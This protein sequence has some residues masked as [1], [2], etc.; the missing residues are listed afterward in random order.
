MVDRRRHGHRRF[1]LHRGDGCD[2]HHPRWLD[3]CFFTVDVYGDTE[4]EANEW[5]SVVITNPVGATFDAGYSDLTGWT[6]DDEGPP[7]L[8]VYGPYDFEGDSGTTAFRFDV[9]LS[10]PVDTPVTF[11]WSTVDG[12]A[13]AGSDYVAVTGATATIPAGSTSASFTVDVYGDTE[14][15]AN[16]WFSVVITNPVGATF[17]ADYSDL[18]GW[19]R[20]D[21]G[22]ATFEVY[23]Y[24]VYEGDSGTTAV[25]F[26]VSLSHPVD[27]PVTFEW[28]TVD[29]T[30]TA[31][32]DYV[33]VTGATATIPAG[34]TSAS[35]TVDVYG[36]TEVEADERFSVV[37]TNPV[38]AT[39]DEDHSNRSGWIR[40]D[41]TPPTLNVYSSSVYEGD[42][43]TTAMTFRGYLSR[44]VDYDVTFEW[45]T[46]G[47]TATAGSDYVAVTGATA[48]IPAG[49]T[50]AE[51][52]TIDVYGDTEVEANEWFSVVITNP[53]G[54]TYASG[55]NP[56]GSIRNDDGPPTLSVYGSSVDEGDSGT[57]P[58]TFGVWLSHPV[59]TPV[60]FEWS[61]VDGTATAGSDY[62]A[63]TGATATIP[64]G[65]TSASFT[66][67]VN[68]DT[69]V[70]ADEW[71]SVVIT[72]PVGATYGASGSSWILDDDT[73]PTLRVY[74]PYDFE[75]DSG[76]TAAT[77]DVSLSHPV[78]TPVT[79]EW[80]TVDRTATAGSDYI[81][82]T[83]ATA[84][85]PAGSTSASFTVDVYGD[86]EVEADEWFSVVITNPVGATYDAYNSDPSGSIRN[87]DGPPTLNVYSD[88]VYEGDSGTTA[89]TFGV[90]L[91]RSVDYDV[92]FEWSTVDGTATAGSD[93]V[94]V[95]GATAT[96]PAGST[97]ASFTV[98]VYGDTEVEANEWFSVVITNPVGATY[99]SGGNP[100]GSIL[101]DDTPPAL[102]VYSD[103]S[104]YEGDSGTTAMTFGVWLSRSVD[105][106]VT[107]EWSTVD[108]TATAGSDYVAVTGATA[109]IPA[110]RTDAELF[111]IDV[112]GDT[113]VEANEWFSVVITNPVG[114]TYAAGGNPSGSILDDDT[115][116]TLSVYGS[117]VDEGDSGTTPMT[118]RGYLSRSVDY[119]V[120]F[121]WSTVDGTATAGSDYVAVTG[122]TATIPAGSW[123]EFTVDVYGDTEAEDDEW[124]QV[125]I[126]NP[127]GATYAS[128]GNP[129]GSIL[130]DEPELALAD[131]AITEGDDGTSTLRFTPT[132]SETFYEDV[133]FTW[134]TQNGSATAGSDY[135]AVLSTP[136]TIPA[137]SL[138]TT[139]EVTV[140]GDTLY[141]A[142]ESFWVV[143]SSL[144]N[145]T[146]A[147]DGT[148]TGTITNDDDPPAISVDDVTITE[149]DSGTTAL[150]FTLSLDA[151]SGLPASVDVATAD[152]TAT[153]ADADYVALSE[154]VTIPAGWTTATLPV[155]INRD[156]TVSSSTSPSTW[157]SPTRSMPTIADATGT[158][159]ITNDDEPELALADVAITEGDDGTSTLRFTPTLSETFYEDVTFTWRTQ[160]GSATA[161]SDYVAV[162]STPVTIPAGSL[163]TTLE[164]TVNGDT[165]YEADESFSVVISSLV[166]ATFADDGTATGT[167]TNDD[168][169]PA[170][171]V[172]DVTITEGDSGTTA[173]VFTLS[174]DAVSGLPA[175]VDVA[176]ADGTATTADADY[177]ALS[178]TVTIPAGWTTATL[179][180]TI[181]RDTTD[182]VRRVLRPGPH[183]PDPCHDRRRH[184]HRHHHQR[185]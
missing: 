127:V 22:P 86:T 16:E 145:A 77:F 107:F 32:S 180:V 132:L 117:S 119:D 68:G 34:S 83:G 47:G 104:V 81:A 2:R 28:S 3:L 54:A 129:S 174:L 44:S 175:S 159:T 90:W 160:N 133:T 23:S 75:G 124:L 95:T 125:V 40:D 79:F 12:T 120:T 93:Y 7:A 69:E 139:L 27:T 153:T 126:T 183:R 106:D 162:L 84:T 25:T 71:F 97:S 42:S 138:S 39:F 63:V 151:V 45:S 64:A 89:M 10:H 130:D 94:A 87:D 36:D 101:D 131:V 60:T 88:S 80:S 185:R 55:G 4:V 38:G 57:T 142:D 105:Y 11:E 56:S 169:P 137:G 76:T 17:D 168:D 29:G 65:S 170:I 184:R 121:E 33:A 102:N 85:I 157:S 116:P 100:S 6:Y 51:L 50:D 67:D 181:N 49:R 37:I 26:D 150:V 152:G 167:I 5:F 114:A 82:V 178:E 91:S 43:G 144:V 173:L 24:S 164:V 118:F 61:T 171:S 30:A 123:A 172:D 149:G 177:V 52:F 113:E 18:T 163:S 148:A 135:V 155:T 166:N 20:D 74:G 46:V 182:R 48:T 15:E 108:G 19:I 9:S 99:A 8:E 53:V 21:D 112:Y 147:D 140:N 35:F 136:V 66:V 156:T 62:I 176:T 109:T 122:A 154:T 143:I 58:M 161:G 41:D 14:V 146:F 158:G 59:D 13:T 92:T 179:P 31:G 78:D 128:G 1:R 72:N 165:L 73:P 110:G 70:E 134:R 115:P 103:S 96:I 98:D 111:T 141:E